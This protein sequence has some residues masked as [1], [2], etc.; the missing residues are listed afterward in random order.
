VT[1]AAPVPRYG[2]ELNWRDNQVAW[3]TRSGLCVTCGG[4]ALM[5]N[6]DG[7]SQHKVCAERA[8]VTRLGLAGALALAA[9]QYPPHGSKRATQGRDGAR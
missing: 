4:M 7:Q 9:A 2:L 1:A 6:S 3:P 8:N 5:S